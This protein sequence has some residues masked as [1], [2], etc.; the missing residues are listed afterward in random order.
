MSVDLDATVF[1]HENALVESTEIKE[2]TRIWAFAHILN[3]AKIGSNCNINDHT[4][5]EG[6]VIIGNYVTIKC[7]V[8]LWNGIRIQDRVFIGPNA[9]FTNDIRPRSKKYLAKSY[10]TYIN[11]GASIGANATIICGITV[12]KWALVGGG[13]VLTR[14]VP[15]YALVYGNPARIK[16]F[17]CEC[18]ENLKFN[19]NAAKCKCNRRYKCVEKIVMRVE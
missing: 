18:G 17:V 7:G 15:D 12:G 3:G 14:D 11:E 16:G 10:N 4:F 6:D 5:I 2:N 9:T 8:Y 13:S 1:I 19:K